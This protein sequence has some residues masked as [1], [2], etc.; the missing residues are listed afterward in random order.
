MCLGEVNDVVIV[1]EEGLPKNEWKL[2]R[3]PEITFSADGLVRKVKVLLGD[4]KLNAKLER[5]NKQPIVERPVQ[6]LVLLLKG[7]K[8]VYLR[9]YE[10]ITNAF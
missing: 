3:V 2:G 9:W 1:K 4:S 6:K 8:C 5:V 7:N 10:I